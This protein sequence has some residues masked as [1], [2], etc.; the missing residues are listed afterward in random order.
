V[1]LFLAIGVPIL[2]LATMPPVHADPADGPTERPSSNPAAAPAAQAPDPASWDAEATTALQQLRSDLEAAEPPQPQPHGSASDHPAGSA[3]LTTASL[4]GTQ[5]TPPDIPDRQDRSGV[6][7]PPPN[8]GHL[9]TRDPDRD[10]QPYTQAP[11]PN[12]EGNGRGN[13]DPPPT[14]QA[15]P[16]GWKLHIAGLEGLTDHPDPLPA[17]SPDPGRPD[18]ATAADQPPAA[19]TSLQP[20]QDRER[21]S[22]VTADGDPGRP[23]GSVWLQAAAGDL[24]AGSGLRVHPRGRLPDLPGAPTASSGAVG[25]PPAT[26]LLGQLPTQ[27]RPAPSS[28]PPADP[29]AQAPPSQPAHVVPAGRVEPA[30]NAL[31]PGLPQTTIVLTTAPIPAGSLATGTQAVASAD[32]GDQRGQ[33]DQL[34]SARLLLD[35]SDLGDGSMTSRLPASSSVVLLPDD[36]QLPP[37]AGGTP[38]ITPLPAGAAAHLAANLQP[39]ILRAGI[40]SWDTTGWEYV[41]ALG[42]IIGG[43]V[44]LSPIGVAYLGTLGAAMIGG[45][46]LGIGSSSGAQRF[47]KGAVNWHQVAVAGALGGFTGGHSVLVGML[48]TRAV[49][50]AGALSGGIVQV[51]GGAANRAL[52][53]DDPFDRHGMVVD[54]ITGQLTGAIGAPAGVSFTRNVRFT[55]ALSL[56]E[57]AGHRLGGTD[58]FGNIVLAMYPG[59]T[60]PSAVEALRHETIHSLI[61]TPPLFRGFVSWSYR[62]SHLWRYA[63]EAIAFAYGGRSL[64]G[65]YQPFVSLDNLT[66]WRIIVEAEALGIGVYEFV[67]PRPQTGSSDDQTGAPSPHR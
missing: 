41:L 51:A 64:A 30:Y 23:A 52:R 3:L 43:L 28:P 11:D 16:G 36:S 17:T 18:Q 25:R 5:P 61:R 19:A 57:R 33:P 27:P 35:I 7:L 8:L 39:S 22:L 63:E 67:R 10:D 12:G 13:G 66:P 15:P 6:P 9:L 20:D 54:L 58:R 62:H 48:A 4:L 60:M 29:D 50:V 31:L 42:L 47:T 53:G 55:W 26:A 65:L 46:L 56:P 38:L 44:A 40:G 32:A 37:G 34:G 14:S 2:V 45:V 59:L 1:C 49:L 24:P 21:A